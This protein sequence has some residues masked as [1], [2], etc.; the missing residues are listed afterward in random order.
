MIDISWG[1]IAV[2]FG[3]GMFFIG[4]KDLPNAARVVGTQ[5]GRVVGLL[6]GARARAD[7]FAA[8]NELKQLQNEL[9]SGLRELDAVKS[10]LAVSM[11]GQGLVGR[12]LGAMVPA[13]NK[14]T[15][16][17]TT[18]T[19]ASTVSMMRPSIPTSA[20]APSAS[21]PFLLR[22]Q[23]QTIGAVAEEEWEKQGIAFRSRAESGSGLKNMDTSTSGSVLLSNLIQQSLIF[24]QYDRAVREQDEA[25]RS[26]IDQVVQKRHSDSTGSSTNGSDEK[27][28]H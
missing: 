6:Q 8:Q 3:V 13:V 9:R 5:I 26:K 4:K 16:V 24:D 15:A 27:K 22:P 28:E 23:S 11:S 25:L 17:S 1:E 19:A 20:S 14:S 12:G 21:A 18:A 7:R 2:V 10:E